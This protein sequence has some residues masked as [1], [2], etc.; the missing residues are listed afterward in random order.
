MTVLHS[1]ISPS[2]LEKAKESTF[3]GLFLCLYFLFIS[4]DFLAETK[5]I[6]R[7]YFFP[8]ISFFIFSY[9]LFYFAQLAEFF[10]FSPANHSSE[11]ALFYFKFGFLPLVV[12]AA[13]N[14]LNYIGFLNFTGKT[15]QYA[16]V[17]FIRILFYL[18]DY[19][20]HVA[21]RLSHKNFLASRLFN[22]KK[23]IFALR[24]IKKEIT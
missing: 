16:C 9:I 1:M 4:W 19:F 14:F 10:Y 20:C 17:V 23:L 3:V 8:K 24:C 18:D 12:A 7:E 13:L 21:Y 11:R 5:A 15:S 22:Q 6:D 2:F